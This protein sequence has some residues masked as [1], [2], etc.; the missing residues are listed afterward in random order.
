MQLF[1]FDASMA[2]RLPESTARAAR[3]GVDQK[4]WQPAGFGS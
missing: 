2:W 4:F 1:C 3:N